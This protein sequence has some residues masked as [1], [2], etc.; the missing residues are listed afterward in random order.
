MDTKNTETKEQVV[1][2]FQRVAF[3]KMAMMECISKGGNT[4]ELAA[5]LAKSRVL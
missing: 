4:T 1:A 5:E 2:F 3:E